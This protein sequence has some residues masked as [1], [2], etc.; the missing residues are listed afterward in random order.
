[1]LQT[2]KCRLDS[3]LN[4]LL[5]LLSQVESRFDGD[6]TCSDSSCNTNNGSRLMLGELIPTW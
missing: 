4:P 5:R 6:A 3:V 2:T 1:M